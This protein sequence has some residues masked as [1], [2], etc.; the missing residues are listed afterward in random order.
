MSKNSSRITE[1]TENWNHQ[2]V[3]GGTR[4]WYSLW[5]GQFANMYQ[6]SKCTYSLSN[7]SAEINSIVT[8]LCVNIYESMS[9]VL[10]FENRKKAT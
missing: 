4:N 5:K 8:H 7:F 9:L 10:L 6:H 2:N 3:I 1:G